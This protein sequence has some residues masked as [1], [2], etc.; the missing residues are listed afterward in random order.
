MSSTTCSFATESDADAFLSGPPLTCSMGR[1]LEGDRAQRDASRCAVGHHV[2]IWW[3]VTKD[4]ALMMLWCDR[5]ISIAYPELMIASYKEDMEEL[6]CQCFQRLFQGCW[7][8]GDI[9]REDQN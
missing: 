4:T 8:V 6:A 7:A 5:A 1:Q 9:A 3:Q 2:G